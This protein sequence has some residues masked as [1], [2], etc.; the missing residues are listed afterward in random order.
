MGV[1]V[2]AVGLLAVEM[3]HRVTV[4]LRPGETLTLRSLVFVRL[5]ARVGEGL[6]HTLFDE[7]ERL[8]PGYAILLDGRN[9]M[10]VGGL[11]A[12]VNEGARVLI[13]AVVSGG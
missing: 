1:E 4:E 6:P 11:D 3:P 8:R 10:Q 7:E 2:Q 5:A 12:A 13:T 9:A